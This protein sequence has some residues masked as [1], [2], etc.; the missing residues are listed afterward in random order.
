MS[1]A[2]LVT[3]VIKSSPHLALMTLSLLW[4]YW[5]LNSRV[6]KTRKAFEK[7]LVTQ[8]MSRED[9]MH[10]SACFEELKTNITQTLKQRAISSLRQP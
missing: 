6:N 5:T 2:S 1:A 7:Q 10:L 3:T 9:A 8:G 4:M